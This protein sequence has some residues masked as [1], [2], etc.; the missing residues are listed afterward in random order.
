MVPHIKRCYKYSEK[1]LENT[2]FMF[3][4]RRHKILISKALLPERIVLLIK[5]YRITWDDLKAKFS[6]V[7]V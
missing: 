6:V 3:C 1:F 2:F 7:F 4:S 5:S